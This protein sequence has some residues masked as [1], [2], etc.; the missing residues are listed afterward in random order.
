[1]QKL[2]IHSIFENIYVLNLDMSNCAL[3]KMAILST[4]LMLGVSK[5][6]SNLKE[7]GLGFRQ[8]NLDKSTGVE[9]VYMLVNS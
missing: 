5:K 4:V 6:F 2:F 7:L 1:M 9:I 8:C 3:E